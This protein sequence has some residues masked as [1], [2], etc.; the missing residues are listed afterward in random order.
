[1]QHPFSALK[2]EYEHNFA[3]MRITRGPQ[4]KRE[5]K[6]LRNSMDRYKA[7]AQTTTVPALV[8]ACLHMR[9]SSA[10]FRT[11]LGNGQRLDRVTTIVPKGRGPFQTW[12]AGA[13]DALH[14]DGLDK[15]GDWSVALLAYEAELFNGFGYRAYGIPSPYLWAG[16]NIYVKGKYVADG[17]F[18]PDAIDPQIGVMP[19]AAR[20]MA[21]DASLALPGS[22]PLSAMSEAVQPPPVGLGESVHTTEWLQKSLNLLLEPSPRLAVDGSYGRRTMAAVRQFEID[23][24]LTVDRGYAGPEV[25]GAIDRKLAASSARVP[26]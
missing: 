2:T 24:R 6:T 21:L 16:S 23:N 3:A 5:V 10:D 25:Y 4:V 26:A 7:V 9:E 14:L 15:A 1:M 11:Y 22:G 12:E 18:S 17:K 8:I 19:L 20:L 13:R